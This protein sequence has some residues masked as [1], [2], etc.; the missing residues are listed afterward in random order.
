MFCY[1]NN[2]FAPGLD[3]GV[4]GLWR[5]GFF[6]GFLFLFWIFH[7][8]KE[9]ALP[10]YISLTQ[11]FQSFNHHRPIFLFPPPFE[12]Q[13]HPNS[14]PTLQCF[15]TDDQLIVGYSMTPAFG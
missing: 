3:E 12:N 4:G 7:V 8:L 1:V 13:K 15:K 5:V 14:H 10:F 6:L 2:I 11:F 9:G